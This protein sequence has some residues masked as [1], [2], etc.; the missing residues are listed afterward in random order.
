MTTITASVASAAS[1][2][3][4]DEK[5]KFSNVRTNV[6]LLGCGKYGCVFRPPPVCLKPSPE[7]KQLHGDLV[8]KVT[9]NESVDQA[10][11]ANELG[12]AALIRKRWPLLGLAYP[13]SEFFILPYPPNVYFCNDR[14]VELPVNPLFAPSKN[15]LYVYYPYGG[16]SL[17]DWL[18]SIPSVPSFSVIGLKSKLIMIVP[19]NYQE[20]LLV[21]AYRLLR[22]VQLLLV[23][24]IQHND[25]HADNIVVSKLDGMPRIIDFG[26]S[27]YD[28][29][30]LTRAVPLE[31]EI[32]WNREFSPATQ[33]FFVA[34]IENL[35]KLVTFVDTKVIE[36]LLYAKKLNEA[37]AAAK[38]LI[39]K[40]A[41][42]LAKKTI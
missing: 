26:K 30:A 38:Q 34:V 6:K 11:L 28:S 7:L 5:E 13:D 41:P 23:M 24:G 39:A 40:A 8:L 15:Q 4:V 12:T 18:S 10:A 17:S 21:M 31:Y 29:Y 33:I 35:L 32:N 42:R 36:D 20:H 25:L 9:R 22:A 27:S 37:T 1:P 14:P 16:E 3:K 19:R 2:G